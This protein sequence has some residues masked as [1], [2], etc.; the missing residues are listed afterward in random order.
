MPF[1]EHT[2]PRQPP[3]TVGRMVRVIFARDAH[4]TVPIPA[5]E[6]DWDFHGDPVL[7]YEVVE[8]RK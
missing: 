4:T 7:A 2:E 8:N 6:V 5:A 3:E 1:A